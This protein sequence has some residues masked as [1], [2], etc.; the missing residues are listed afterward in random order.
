VVTW[1]E[2]TSMSPVGYNEAVKPFVMGASAS[3]VE[4]RLFDSVSAG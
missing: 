1:I 2:N 4:G 3:A